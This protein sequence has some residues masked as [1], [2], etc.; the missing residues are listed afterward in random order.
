MR[1]NP[2]YV[3]PWYLVIGESGSGKTSAIRNAGLS[4]PITDTGPTTGISATRNCDWWFFEEAVILDTA[5]RY[6]IP[7]DEGP[8]KEEWKNFLIPPGKVPA[9]GTLERRHRHHFRR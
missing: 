4:S 6:T 7:I 3:L 9:Q 2:L 8:D 5:G 1:G